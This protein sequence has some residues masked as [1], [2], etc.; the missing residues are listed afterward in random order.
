MIQKRFSEREDR[1]VEI[2]ATKQKNE[3]EIFLK[4]TV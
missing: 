1:I 4:R 3:K 2:P